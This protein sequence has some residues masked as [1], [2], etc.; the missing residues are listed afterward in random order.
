MRSRLAP[1]GQYLLLLLVI[2]V[3]AFFGL[4]AGW[5]SLR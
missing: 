5:W 1:L 2:A 4:L 3:V